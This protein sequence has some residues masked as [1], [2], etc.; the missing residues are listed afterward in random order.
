[1][2]GYAKA[3]SHTQKFNCHKLLEFEVGA[4]MSQENFGEIAQYETGYEL[5]SFGLPFVLKDLTLKPSETR[6]SKIK[7]YQ[8]L[9]KDQA[10]NSTD[11]D[12]WIDYLDKFD[13]GHR[14][15]LYDQ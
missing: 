10:N 15:P 1:M 8:E 14:I 12:Y 13:I 5:S 9:L 4:P 7:F 11:M 6:D 3:D 2:I